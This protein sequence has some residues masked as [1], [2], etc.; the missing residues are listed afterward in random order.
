M[1]RNVLLEPGPG[2]P[3]T[4]F[5]AERGELVPEIRADIGIA[6]RRPGGTRSV[7]PA[8]RELDAEC[9]VSEIG[10]EPVEAYARERPRREP[11]L[12]GAQVLQCL[13]EASDVGGRLLVRIARA[14]S[15]VQ[16][17]QSTTD[18][19]EPYTAGR[20][21]ELRKGVEAAAGFFV[22]R[23]LFREPSRASWL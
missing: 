12:A 2:R 20:K 14:L 22:S 15:C 18:R 3:C 17:V 21:P 9:L 6:Q 23:E 1:L 13:P 11:G 5:S 7:T 19:R 10:A 4:G 16:A 8:S